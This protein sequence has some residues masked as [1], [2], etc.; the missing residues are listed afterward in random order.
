MEKQSRSHHQQ[1]CVIKVKSKKHFK[2][3]LNDS[4]RLASWTFESINSVISLC[5]IQC[6][7]RRVLRL[8][9]QQL[10]KVTKGTNQRATRTQQRRESNSQHRPM[11]EQVGYSSN[12]PILF[13]V[14][15]ASSVLHS[16]LSCHCN[17]LK[18]SVLASSPGG[19]HPPHPATEQTEVAPPRVRTEGQQMNGII[20]DRSS[21]SST[22]MLVSSVIRCSL[23]VCSLA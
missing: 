9:P 22:D 21:L 16:L 1:V 6:L 10:S 4:N 8:L 11:L 2:K 5:Q 7:R 12:I 3:I 18:T 20:E 15:P 14:Y 17:D 13:L 23:V 19:E